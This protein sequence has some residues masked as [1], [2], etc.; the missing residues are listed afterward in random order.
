MIGH[1]EHNDGMV[2]QRMDPLARLRGFRVRQERGR[3]MGDEYERLMRS[4]SRVS[5][6]H[7]A[8][9]SAWETAVPDE[10]RDC[11]WMIRIKGGR[12]EVGVSN[13]GARHRV[14]RWLRTGG[15]ELVRGLAKVSVK[16]VVLRVGERDEG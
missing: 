9:G 11:A 6:E 2:P 8:V 13:A 16:S 4:L 7:S 10:L 14:D 12:L 15:L 3:G 5:L 1:N